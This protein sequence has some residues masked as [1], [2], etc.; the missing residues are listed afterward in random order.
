MQP[1]RD[2]D[3][4]EVGSYRLIGRLGDTTYLGQQPGGERVVIKLLHPD[5]DPER[6]MR[7]IEPLQGASAFCT[8]QILDSGTQDG[9]P[10]VV[11]E[12]I[13]GPTLRAAAEAGELLR[14]AA[15]HRFAVGTA[16]ALVAIHQTGVVHGDIG[17]DN[18]VLGPD[19]PRVINFGVARAVQAT[20][21][22]TTRKVDVPAFTAPERLQGRE[23]EPAADMFSWAATIAYAASGRSPFDGGSM[24]G[25]VNK[26]MNAEP[27]L[28]ELGDLRGLVLA[29]L[30]KDPARRPSASEALLRL[31]GETGF[32]TGSVSAAL[33]PPSGPAYDLPP[34]RGATTTA[35]VRRM[36]V[37]LVAV[38]AFLAGG[39]LTG[40]TVY[41][42]TGREGPVAAAPSASPSGPVITSAPPI[43]PG[44]TQAPFASVA[45][46]PA[47]NTKL[48][49][50]GVMLHEHPDDAVHLAAYLQAKAP[51]NAF[52][53]EPSGKFKAVGLGEEP[54]LSPDG[55]W[56]ALNP[57]LK[58]QG[59]DMDQ[60]NFTNLA[61]GEKFT[62]TTVKKPQQ[63]WFPVWSRDS[64]RLL[65]SVTDEK[66]ERITGFALIDVT[67]KKATVVEA[68]YHDDIRLTYAFTPDG[69]IVRGYGNGKSY[70]MEFYNLSGQVV[71]SMH[72]VGRPPRAPDWYSPSGKQF[73]TVCPN[74][75]DLCVW[76]ADTGV[77]RATVP[78]ISSEA[79][80]LGWFDEN[81]LLI[82]QPGKG[83]KDRREGEVRIVDFTGD[84][85]RVLADVDP[86]SAS[87]QWAPVVR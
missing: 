63:T 16:T 22:A 21:A 84:V 74:G 5:A 7:V 36:G 81:H 42:L 38:V 45:P 62:V 66:R 58:F 31:V 50:I 12:Y 30:A 11:S 73:L 34:P 61:T 59:S 51:F 3:P 32:L 87:L 80:L 68:E 49:D 9:R 55:R 18:V 40:G 77:R 20:G 83:K 4:A 70:G 17:P 76:N 14:D 10:Y 27:D 69:T 6:F 56:V 8:A 15:L 33:P 24:A 52:V 47:T 23:I 28:P 54:S 25:T 19:G 65:L 1:L 64:R 35:P 60:V 67:T 72:W 41:T 71:R 37:V 13:D 78:K 86:L 43:T 2:V 26:I 46:T 39:V 44:F 48:P 85:A 75:E 79:G 53:R 82:H 57:W 29:C